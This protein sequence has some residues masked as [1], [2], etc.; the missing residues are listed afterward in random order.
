MHEKV[1]VS[2]TNIMPASI[3]T[4]LF[5]KSRTKIGVKPQGLPP[6]YK[7]EAVAEAILYA[8][9]H[10]IREL[11]VGGAGQAMQLMQR[12]SPGLMDALMNQVGFQLQQ[13]NQPKSED[14]PDNLD[15]AITGYDKVEGDFSDQARPSLFTWLETHPAAKWGVLTAVG[16]TALA[17]LTAPVRNGNGII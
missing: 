9:E 14:A 5:D 15:H 10:P 2:V 7:P 16:I 3:N 13:T 8:A 11:I 12:I 17:I 1:P 4:P 6:F